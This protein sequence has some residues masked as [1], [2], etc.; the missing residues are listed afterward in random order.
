MLHLIEDRLGRE[1]MTEVAC[2][3]QHPF[4]RDEDASQKVPVARAGSTADDLP[5]HH[6]RRDP[7]V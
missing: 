1:C 2:W 3:F 4:M 7:A 5:P 6:P